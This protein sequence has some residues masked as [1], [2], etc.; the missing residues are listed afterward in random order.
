[1]GIETD[2]LVKALRGQRAGALAKRVADVAAKNQGPLLWP[3]LRK[4]GPGGSS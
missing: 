4:Q 2:L 3:A 1:V